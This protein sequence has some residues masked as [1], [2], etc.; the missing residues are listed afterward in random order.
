[1]ANFYSIDHYMSVFDPTLNYIS[2][3]EDIYDV[4]S[5]FDDTK[6]RLL[7]LQFV[8]AKGESVLPNVRGWK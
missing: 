2:F 5:N 1:M 4:K 7:A 6:K 3:L 8:F